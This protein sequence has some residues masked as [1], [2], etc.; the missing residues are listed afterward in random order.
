M[1]LVALVLAGVVCGLVGSTLGI[2]GGALLVPTLVLGFNIPM[3]EAVPVSL[4]CVVANSCA[5]SASPTERQVADVRLALVL[6][7]AT[8]LGA[9]A[10]G[11]LAALLVPALVAFAFGAFST[12]VALQMIFRRPSES[13]ERT[14]PVSPKNLPLGIG[15]SFVAGGI[16]AILGVGGGPVKVPLMAFGMGVPFRVAAATSNMMVGITA[17]ASVVAYAVR[18][19]LHLS[20]AAPLVVGV[21]GGGLFGA[22]RLLQVRTVVLRR[23]FAVVLLAV[24][25]QMLWKGGASLWTRA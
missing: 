4:L 18:G 14:E 6:E 1:H 21:M 9:V 8:V 23:L 3:V 12:L 25:L 7:L 22:A 2:G 13:D 5:A 19:Q 15:G 17:A 16:S 10:G 11:V 20:L 24:A